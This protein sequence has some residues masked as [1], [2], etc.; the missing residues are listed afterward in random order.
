MTQ[1]LDPLNLSG[2][3]LIRKE[4]SVVWEERKEISLVI[5]CWHMHAVVPPH[6]SVCPQVLA[7]PFLP[8]SKPVLSHWPWSWRHSVCTTRCTSV[9]VR[10]HA[11]G[12]AGLTT[13]QGTGTCEERISAEGPKERAHLRCA[14]LIVIC[15]I[16]HC[17]RYIC[18]PSFLSSVSNDPSGAKGLRQIDAYP[19][20]C[21]SYYKFKCGKCICISKIKGHIFPV[22][23]SLWLSDSDPNFSS[24]FRWAA[25]LW[26]S[27]CWIK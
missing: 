20:I 27:I 26:F 1:T 5:C 22:R 19:Q 21:T 11:Y 13:W 15:D 12:C 23:I 18:M 7:G 14:E 25:D 10:R 3:V 2:C 17:R 4:Y 9:H 6:T 8:V 24:F 16:C